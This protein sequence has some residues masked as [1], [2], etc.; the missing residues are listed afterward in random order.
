LTLCAAAFL[1]AASCRYEPQLYPAKDVL[2]PGPEVKIIAIT[3]DGN[4]IVNKAFMLWVEDLKLEIKRLRRE[5]ERLRE[6]D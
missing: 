4:V 3:Q 5:T 6:E 1:A 2:Q